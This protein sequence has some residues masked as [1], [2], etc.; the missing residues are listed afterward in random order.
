[1]RCAS[2]IRKF[3]V[4]RH[5]RRNTS[6][7][8]PTALHTAF[9]FPPTFVDPRDCRPV[10]HA[11]DSGRCEG[12]AEAHLL[13]EKKDSE[14]LQPFLHS[15]IVDSTFHHSLKRMVPLSLQNGKR[16]ACFS[17]YSFCILVFY[18]EEV[19]PHVTVIPILQHRGFYFPPA[20]GWSPSLSR[21]GNV[22]HA[23]VNQ[24]L[25]SC[26]LRE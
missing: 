2:D 23:S 13:Q 17:S 21:E 5:V 4:A 12:C 20:A 16:M 1:M 24:L 11:Y 15:N 14:H 10:H 8:F 9:Y 3:N 22:S 25:H 7:Y 19:A 18:A 6:A 26:P